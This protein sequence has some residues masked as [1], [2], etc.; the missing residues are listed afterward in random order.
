MY[1]DLTKEQKDYAVFL[2]ALSGFYAT[3]IGKQR[4]EEY[5]DN[6]RIPYSNGMEAMNW[7]NKKDGMFNYHWTL[8]SAGHA[9]LDINKDS[10]KEDMVRNRDR[11]NSWLLGDSGGFQIGKGVWEGDWKDPNCPKAQKKREQVLA[12]MDAYM[13]YGMILDIPAWVSRS[14]E[15]QKATGITKYQD[16]VTE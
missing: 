12:W 7:L 9:E 5:V 1:T 11:N 6:N 10:P 15:G 2:P 3:F 8:Y 4:S 14:P 16:A 13:D